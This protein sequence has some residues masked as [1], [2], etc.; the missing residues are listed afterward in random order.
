[1]DTAVH[2]EH[3]QSNI[4]LERES[5]VEIWN[6]L[7]EISLGPGGKVGVEVRSVATLAMS[8]ARVSDAVLG[9]GIDMAFANHVVT[10]PRILMGARGVPRSNWL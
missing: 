3:D 6:G 9:V 8:T 2:V 10:L 4:G 1:M 5:A 7:A